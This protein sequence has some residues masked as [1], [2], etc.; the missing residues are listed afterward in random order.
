MSDGG[1]RENPMKPI[2]G[3]AFPGY[4]LRWLKFINAI[5]R[6]PAPPNR[7]CI[8]FCYSPFFPATSAHSLCSK[9]L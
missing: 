6:L 1:R 8:R 5:V 4:R 7:L 3:S 9:E 2:G